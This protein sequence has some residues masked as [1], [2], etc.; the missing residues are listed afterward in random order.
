MAAMMPCGPPNWL[1]WL[2]TPVVDECAARITE[3]GGQDLTGPMKVD[4]I[5]THDFCTV[6]RSLGLHIYAQIKF[7]RELSNDDESEPSPSND[8]R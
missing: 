5:S 8:S 4:A 3:N 6:E 7:W 2:D 1:G